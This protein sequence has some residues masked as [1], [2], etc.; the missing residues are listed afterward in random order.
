MEVGLAGI[1]R[2]E[3]LL[4]LSDQIPSSER[5][6]RVKRPGMSLSQGELYRTFLMGQ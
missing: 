2:V 4:L 6:G 5:E 1:D 3:L